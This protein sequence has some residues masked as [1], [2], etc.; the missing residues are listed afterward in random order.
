LC[1]KYFTCFNKNSIARATYQHETYPS[2]SQHSEALR[3]PVE[4][5]VEVRASLA[6][7]P[8]MEGE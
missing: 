1:D 4:A 8:E 5:V 7:L 6:L 2:M 3:L